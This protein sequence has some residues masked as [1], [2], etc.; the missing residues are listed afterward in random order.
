[1]PGKE[2]VMAK[3]G[4]S[5]K[6]VIAVVV[7]LVVIAAAGGWF[8]VSSRGEVQSAAV[9][10]C[11]ISDTRRA[12]LDDAAGGEVAAFQVADDPVNVSGTT[13]NTREGEQ[14]SIA[15]WSGRTVLLNLWA[16]WCAPCRREMPHLDKLQADLG[17]E[18]FEVVAV[19]L[20]MGDAEK[21]KKF[22]ADIGL[23]EMGFF[24][25]PS[26][27]TLTDLKKQG[28]V[29]GLPATL[30]IDRRGCAL[31]VLNGPAEWASDDAKELV[32]VAMGEG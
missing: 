15:D 8:Y 29:Y 13:F 31:G 20:D 32:K 23:K 18:N 7:A 10:Q 2:V 16:T 12:A 22:Y 11:A 3:Q 4:A 9:G 25:D 27:D 5:H 26:L 14:T 1:M 21:P 6:G 30:L 19:S 28:L 24:H 17:G